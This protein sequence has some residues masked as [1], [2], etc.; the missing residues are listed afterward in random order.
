[1]N[2]KVKTVPILL[3]VVSIVLLAAIACQS[4]PEPTDRTWQVSSG[5]DPDASV[6]GTVSYRERLA[7]T[8]GATLIVELRDVSLADGPCSAH[9]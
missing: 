7:L 2:T 8:P 6:S 5:L 4:D 9:C 1:M 3:I